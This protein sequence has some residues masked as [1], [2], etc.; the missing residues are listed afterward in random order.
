MDSTATQTVRQRQKAD[1]RA[2][3]LAAAT[4]LMAARGYLGVR[5][6]DI[7]A[8]AGVSGPAVYRHF[9]S[10]DAVLTELLIGV[11][12]R[13]LAGAERILAESAG[14][15]ALRELVDW[16]VHFALTEPELILI[17]DRDRSHLPPS[18][19]ERMR[20]TQ[21]R[22]VALW[23]GAVGRAVPSGDATVDLMRTHAVLGLIN[24]TPR[25]SRTVPPQTRRAVVTQMALA[26]LGD[27]AAPGEHR[28]IGTS[29]LE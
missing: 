20:T 23:V 14:P 21:R 2:A 27:L 11:S 6:E 28:A 17:D 15:R 18:A 25:A 4:Q 16:H 29:A 1:R 12:E 19:L 8:A 5:L 22:Y 3:L 9:A 26:A 24:S 10:K 13:L 7:G